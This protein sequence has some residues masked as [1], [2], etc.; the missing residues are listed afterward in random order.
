MLLNATVGLLGESTLS[1]GLSLARGLTGSGLT[2]ATTATPPFLTGILL[3]A[4]SLRMRLLLPPS[5]SGAVL[6]VEVFCALRVSPSRTGSG[7]ADDSYTYNT[8][9]YIVIVTRGSCQA[10]R[11]LDRTLLDKR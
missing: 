2:T 3:R 5:L 7:P 6:I 9:L 4:G 11:Y 1:L 8:L 10:Y